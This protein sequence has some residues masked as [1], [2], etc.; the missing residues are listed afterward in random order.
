MQR[1]SPGGKWVHRKGFPAG[2]LEA[3]PEEPAQ[4]CG[5]HSVL[6]AYGGN[7]TLHV[8]CTE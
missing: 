6:E 3:E 7:R 1:T 4:P 5:Y 2:R 8:T